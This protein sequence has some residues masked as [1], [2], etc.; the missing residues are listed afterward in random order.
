MDLVKLRDGAR[1]VT[2]R[3]DISGLKNKIMK[4]LNT[5]HLI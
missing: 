4:L 5:R 2:S 1:L 3:Q